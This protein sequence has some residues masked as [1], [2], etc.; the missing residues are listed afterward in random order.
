[1]PSHWTIHCPALDAQGRPR[2]ELFTAAAS[3]R[4]DERL[5]LD[6]SLRSHLAISLPDWVTRLL[7]GNIVG[8]A[9]VAPDIRSAGFNLYITRN[10]D[11][12]KSY[13]R[14]RYAG[15]DDARFGLL[16]SNKDRSLP[17][18]GIRNDYPIQKNLKN[19]VGPY[20]VD[21]PSSRRSCCQLNDVATPFECQGLEF[22]FPIVC[23]GD[24]LWWSGSKWTIRAPRTTLELDPERLRLN[25]YR[26]L[27]TRGRDGMIIFVPEIQRLNDTFEILLKAGCHQ[28]I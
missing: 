1:M 15:E 23:W 4:I 27:L 25:S 19:H 9:L 7:N 14:E 18:F 21:P 12:A 13:V 22:D 6:Q 20:F 17:R 11:A 16:A 8:A 24:D 5:S 26:V 10:I 3:V 2:S 28:L